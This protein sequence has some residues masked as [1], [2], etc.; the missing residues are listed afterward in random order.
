MVGGRRNQIANQSFDSL[1]G[2]P[3]V[4]G[5]LVGRAQRS[6]VDIAKTCFGSVMWGYLHSKKELHSTVYWDGQMALAGR[7]SGAWVHRYC[8]ERI[9]LDSHLGCGP[10]W[11]YGS[12]AV[13]IILP[14]P[15]AD[16]CSFVGNK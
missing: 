2:L 7:G 9:V 1:V 12:S 4:V 8:D 11:V 16:S 13:P 6:E 10:K 14:L 15:Y 5:N 3:G